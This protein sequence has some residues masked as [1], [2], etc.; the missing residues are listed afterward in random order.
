MRNENRE[1]FGHTV[2]LTVQALKNL[3]IKGFQYVSV[4]A[5]TKDRRLDYMEPHYIVL[6]PLHQLPEERDK[7]GI[8]EPVDSP[9]LVDWANTP[10][11]GIKV[12]V[13]I[14]KNTE[15]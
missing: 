14:S 7:K 3:Q 11:D 2:P 5:Y 4:N 9:V 10:D 13:S 1:H 12:F 15:L 6:V 8:Y